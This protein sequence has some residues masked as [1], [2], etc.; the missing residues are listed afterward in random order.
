MHLMVF[1]IKMC[2]NYTSRRLFCLCSRY[3]SSNHTCL[4]LSYQFINIYELQMCTSANMCFV[5][6][7]IRCTTSVYK[8][9]TSSCDGE[10]NFLPTVRITIWGFLFMFLEDILTKGAQRKKVLVKSQHACSRK[11]VFPQLK[12]CYLKQ[13]VCIVL[14]LANF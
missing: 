1:P 4:F 10:G 9:L 8:K 7:G 13:Q 6:P 5:C 11:C 3:D 2:V 12:P 14:V